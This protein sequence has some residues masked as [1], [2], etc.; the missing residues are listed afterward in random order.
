M[1]A[2]HKPRDARK[3]IGSY[4]PRI[5]ASEKAHGRAPY[6]D[7][8]I[9]ERHYPGLLHARVLRS[10]YPRARIV[11]LDAGKAACLPGVVAIL[12]YQ[13]PEVARLK[14][15]NA[16]WTDAVD[17]VSYEKMMWGKFRDRRVLGDYAAWAGDEVG[18]AVAAES[19]LIAE[20]AL[21]LVD[22]EWEVLPFVLDPLTVEGPTVD[23]AVQFL[24]L[25]RDAHAA[26]HVAYLEDDAG[27]LIV[28][29]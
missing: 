10:P 17:T 6:A 23:L 12:T 21:R 13:D 16:G 7:D 14:P 8:M 28:I 9:S 1:S 18:V 20:Q 22:V 19:E 24:R 2:P 11:R 15:T 5:D 3:F 29:L 27:K 26:A 25:C 4:R